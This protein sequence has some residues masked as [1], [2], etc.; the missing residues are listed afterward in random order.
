M[1]K[2]PKQLSNWSLKNRLVIGVLLLSAIGITIADFAAQSALKSYLIGQ[3]D[4][5]LTAV[6]GGAFLRLDRAGIEAD[7]DDEDD[8]TAVANSSTTKPLN[9]VPSAISVTL[10]TPNGIII[11]NLGGE[12][13]NNHIS[14][15][16]IGL[17][18]EQVR[19][20]NGVPF[21]I[22]NK[23]AHF[24]VLARLLPSGAGS[25]VAAISLEE[26]E[27]TLNRLRLL[28]FFIGFVVL[29]LIGILSLA[30]VRLSLKPL[31]AVETTANAIARGDLSARLPEANPKTEVGRL[32]ESL[33]SMLSKIED[34]FA[35]RKVSEDK[36]RRFVADASHELRTPLTAIRGFAELHRQGAMQGAEK[37]AEVIRRI[38]EESKRMGSLVEDLLLLA[39]LDQA[40]P[41]V[42]KPVEINQ[43]VDDVIAT[44][45]VIF[46]NQLFTALSPAAEV[47]ILGD[48]EKIHQAISN[49]VIN[50]CTYS[51]DGSKIE[52]ATKEL[53]NQVLISVKDNGP[54][55]GAD[56]KERIF[57]RFYRADTSRARPTQDGRQEGRQGSGLGLSIVD[58]IMSAHGGGVSVKSEPGKG[59]E[60]TLA[61]PI[62]NL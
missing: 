13:S 4:D 54:G 20:A 26:I 7:D 55:L 50:A 15:A 17:S 9:R 53:E 10:L 8:I 19:L 41:I 34:A 38:E 27:K 5:Q 59:S 12:L 3:A 25:A 60:F 47:F 52:I 39:R 51:P 42:Q 24:R 31:T 57:E 33:N 36:L 48:P 18:A 29:L 37:S 6:A 58:A 32:T 30:V 1:K 11:G 45:N 40:R 23:H 28:F 62:E 43:V 46:P 21:T 61:F 44:S 35:A 2:R 16:V 22:E 14:D 56:Q 49:L